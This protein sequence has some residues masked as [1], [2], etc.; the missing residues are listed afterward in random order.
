MNQFA[1]AESEEWILLFVLVKT[2]G[3]LLGPGIY[4]RAWSK[5]LW[6]GRWKWSCGVGLG[7][8]HAALW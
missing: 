4:G 2:G 8:E 7:K 1:V 5:R 6:W 3:W